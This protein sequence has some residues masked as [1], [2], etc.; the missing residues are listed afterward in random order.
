MGEAVAVDGLWR[1]DGAVED[2]LRWL[3]EVLA[4]VVKR[5]PVYLLNSV[6][7]YRLEGQKTPAFE[8]LEQ[9]EWHV[10]EHLIVPG[11]NL[12]N[13]SALGKGFAGDEAPRV[14]Q[15]RAEDL[16]D[17]GGGSESAVSLDAEGR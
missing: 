11:G 4:E 14:H 9:M 1:D 7:P 10:P 6:N 15:A 16:G 13:S 17:P 2:G 12:A 8:M 3:R 5:A